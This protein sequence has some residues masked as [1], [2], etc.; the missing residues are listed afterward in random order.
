M[1]RPVYS[2]TIVLFITLLHK[3]L[4]I[5]RLGGIGWTL[6]GGG[7]EPMEDPRDAALRE[8]YEEVKVLVC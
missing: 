6:P 8:A 2:C 5:T 3:V 7:I 1:G 4:L